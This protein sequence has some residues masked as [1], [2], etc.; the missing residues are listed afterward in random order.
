M[1]KDTSHAS[2]VK[3]HVSKRDGRA[4]YFALTQHNMGNSKFEE[5]VNAAEQMVLTRIW[6]D[7]NSRY[8]LKQHI[9]RHRDAYNDMVRASQNITYALPEGR[10]RVSILLASIATTEP[11]IVSAKTQILSNVILMVNFEDAVE[12]LLLVCPK[13]PHEPK[14][15]HRISA[16]NTGDRKRRRGNKDKNCEKGRSGVSLRYHKMHEYKKLSEDQKKELKEWRAK[17]NDAKT[18]L[19]SQVETLTQQISALKTKFDDRDDTSE[20]KSKK[21]KSNP[22]KPPARFNQREADAGQTQTDYQ[23]SHMMTLRGAS[24]AVRFDQLVID[25]LCIS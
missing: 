24:L 12:L 23:V 10:T 7:K 2:S 17:Q 6:N 11:N 20:P 21:K 19:V 4:A 13:R 22:L 3:P 25:L 8:S 14:T 9:C 16:V 1:S 5:L 15:E 18:Q